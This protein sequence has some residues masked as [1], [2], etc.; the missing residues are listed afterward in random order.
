MQLLLPKCGINKTPN[1][2]IDLTAIPLRFIATGELGR[3]IEF[4]QTK[5]HLA[6]TLSPRFI[7][8]GEARGD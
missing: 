7:G 1:K 2:A 6:T 3:P 4:Y 5:K 8:T